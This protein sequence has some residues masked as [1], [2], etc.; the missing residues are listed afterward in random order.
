MTQFTFNLEHIITANF[1]ADWRQILFAAIFC[2]KACQMLSCFFIDYNLNHPWDMVGLVWV[3]LIQVPG[4][5]GTLC[6]ESAC[7]PLLH[8]FIDYNLNH[9]WDMVGLVLVDLIQVHRWGGTLCQE[10]S[11]PP[12]LHLFIDYNLNH[13]SWHM[14]GFGGTGSWMRRDTS[15]RILMSSPSPPFH[16]L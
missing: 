7:P 6:Q 10:S 8:L 16:R 1:D 14:V 12:L 4:W 5:G 11:C 2:A 3:D 15:W 13:P 9:P